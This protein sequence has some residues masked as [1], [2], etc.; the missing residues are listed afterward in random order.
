M[1]GASRKAL[2]L[3]VLVA[4]S[5]AVMCALPRAEAPAQREQARRGAQPRPAAPQGAPSC[6][7]ELGE[8]AAFAVESTTRDVRAEEDDHLRGTLSWE[9]V[10]ALAEDRWRL[11]AALHDVSLTQALTLP[12]ERV[13]GSLAEPF[14]IDVDSSCRFVGF[15][16]APEWD[17]RRRQLVRSTLATHEYV[18]PSGPAKTRWRAAQLDGLGDYEAR[19]QLAPAG[20]G[21]EARVQRH[22]AAYDAAANAGA[23]GLTLAVVGSEAEARFDRARPR[24]L[25]ASSGLERV[26][27]RVQGELV[28]DLMQRFRLRRDDE[29]FAPVPAMAAGDADFRDVFDLEIERDAA[30]AAQVANMSPE[31][32][33]AAFR[34]RLQGEG[35]Q[36]YAAARELAA[37]L[38]SHPEGA[39]QVAA[40]L[41][42]G[43]IEEAARP[44]LFLGL[45]LSGTEAARGELSALLVDARVS[46]VDRAR[47]ASALSDIG[48]PTRGTAELLRAQVRERG[49]AMVAS[50]SALGLGSMSRRSD[51]GELRAYVRDALHEELREGLA[52]AD[53]GKVRVALDAMGN[54]G[55]AAF[56]EELAAHLEADSPAT[57]RHA[58]EA[59]GRLDPA[60]SG[61]RLLER[62]RE[63]T[64]PAVSAALVGAYQGPP[65]ADAIALM[66]DKLGASASSSERAAF[67]TWLGTASRSEPEAMRQLVAHA[68][69]ETD[70][71]LLQ[72]I[73]TFVPAEALR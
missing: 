26:Q 65:T 3:V 25:T 1:S 63:E 9:V 33:L 36:S 22:K 46:A 57:R 13:E 14:F 10:D 44:A 58:A 32:A 72:K 62:L 17:A 43:A 51:D 52:A 60:E 55:D 73:G 40:A 18:L 24:W 21:A 47:A 42:A 29:L 35:D 31:E 66:A 34:A 71:R 11:R 50:V 6:H 15:G 20:A 39:A 49:D 68:Q 12:D 41:R 2:A 48:A 30:V 64:E 38:K 69:R 16:F 67:I 37:W 5:S 27:I 56:T 59:L 53:A 54:T 4:A 19:Y 7:F 28:A 70:T 8:T 61:P 23:F 45:E